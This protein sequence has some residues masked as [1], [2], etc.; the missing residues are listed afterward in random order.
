MARPRPEQPKGHES[1][2]PCFDCD[3]WAYD[4]IFWEQEELA[5]GRNPWNQQP[6]TPAQ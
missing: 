4:L 5:E 3:A 6:V 2:C 1:K